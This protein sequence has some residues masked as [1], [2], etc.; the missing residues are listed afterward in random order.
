MNKCECCGVETSNPKYCCR[1]C[2]GKMNNKKHP[3]R[4]LMENNCKHCGVKIP[5]ANWKVRRTACDSCRGDIVDWTQVTYGETKAKR[6]YQIHSRVRDLARVAYK[7]SGKPLACEECGYDTHV[8]IHHKK[9]IGEHSDDTSIAEINS[10]ENLMCL[11]PNH[12]W[13]IHNGCFNKG[14]AGVAEEA[15]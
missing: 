6:K 2:A 15:F 13:E 4:K 10:M 9:P 7:R 11:C 8:V 5:R 1:S 12:H 3:K 14:N